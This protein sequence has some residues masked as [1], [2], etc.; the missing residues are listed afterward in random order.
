ML[1]CIA[2]SVDWSWGQPEPIK[3]GLKTLGITFAFILAL[4][5]LI[6]SF[7]VLIQVAA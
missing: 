1:G 3:H 6:M 2:A 5:L 4:E 7:V